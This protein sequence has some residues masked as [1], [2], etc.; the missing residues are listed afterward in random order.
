MVLSVSEHCLLD[1]TGHHFI[2]PN[3]IAI[4]P[5]ALIHL[6]TKISAKLLYSTGDGQ[7]YLF[8][9]I[10]CWTFLKILPLDTIRVYWEV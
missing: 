5:L 6:Q 4:V 10:D 1:V 8:T 2:N 7:L 9:N 3:T